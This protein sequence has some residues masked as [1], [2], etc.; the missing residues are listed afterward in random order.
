ML[1]W[2]L[3]AG[4]FFFCFGFSDNHSRYIGMSKGTTRERKL[5]ADATQQIDNWMRGGVLD[6]MRLLV[7]LEGLDQIVVDA[8]NVW[9][10]LFG[11]SIKDALLKFAKQ[12]AHRAE[13]GLPLLNEEELEAFLSVAKDSM[14]HRTKHL[15]EFLG[16]VKASHLLIA[17]DERK[18]MLPVLGKG[19]VRNTF[20]DLEVAKH[21][22]GNL[23]NWL[24]K[25]KDGMRGF[26]VVG[27]K[28]PG[29][30]EKAIR[31]FVADALHRSESGRQVLRLLVA[32]VKDRIAEVM[33]KIV[34]DLCEAREADI[35]VL[36][37]RETFM[38]GK[39]V[40]RE[41]GWRVGV[42]A[43]DL[44]VVTE[45][46]ARAESEVFLNMV[47]LS[48]TKLLVRK[49]RACNQ[50]ILTGKAKR[51]ACEL[52]EDDL[53]IGNHQL[54]LTWQQKLNLLFTHILGNVDYVV[55]AAET[56]LL[57][58]AD[59]KTI[60][61]ELFLL[62][63]RAYRG[64][65]KQEA[66]RNSGVVDV[67]FA[68]LV[69]FLRDPGMR[70]DKLDSL[71][72]EMGETARM[73]LVY[74]LELKRNLLHILY[75][76]VSRIMINFPLLQNRHIVME[77]V[78]KLF[79]PAFLASEDAQKIVV[80][81]ETMELPMRPL[82]TVT[83]A[84]VTVFLSVLIPPLNVAAK[85]PVIKRPKVA[86]D[87]APEERLVFRKAEMAGVLGGLSE[88][89]EVV[90]RKVRQRAD[91]LLPVIAA[92]QLTYGGLESVL[93]WLKEPVGPRPELQTSLSEPLVEGMKRLLIVGVAD[94]CL[95]ATSLL[96][97]Q[98]AFG[99][100][101]RLFVAELLAQDGA[102]RVF[103]DSVLVANERHVKDCW[104]CEAGMHGKTEVA[105][106]V[107]QHAH[108]LIAD[109]KPDVVVA[110]GQ[111]ASNLYMGLAENV[112]S[113][114]LPERAATALNVKAAQEELF[115]GS[116]NSSF[117][118]TAAALGMAGGD[119]ELRLYGQYCTLPTHFKIGRLEIEIQAAQRQNLT[120]TKGTAGLTTAK[121]NK[122]N[123]KQKSPV[124]L[125]EI[126]SGGYVRVT[127]TR[128]GVPWTAVEHSD[129]VR[130]M[131]KRKGADAP[132]ELAVLVCNRLRKCVYTY[133]QMRIVMMLTDQVR[134]VA[135]A[136]EKG[137]V[138]F[139]NTAYK[140]IFGLFGKA[141]VK[142]ATES[143]CRLVRLPGAAPVFVV[144]RDFFLQEV[145]PFVSGAKLESCMATFFVAPLAQD[146]VTRLDVV[147]RQQTLL[148][149]DT[150]LLVLSKGAVRS[151]S[152]AIWFAFSDEGD[153]KKMK[154]SLSTAEKDVELD[155]WE[156]VADDVVVDEDWGGTK[157]ALTGA[158]LDR[159]V[160]S[161]LQRLSAALQENA[162]A[163]GATLRKLM[164]ELVTGSSLLSG[165]HNEDNPLENWLRL[166]KSG[167]FGV[168]SGLAPRR[169]EQVVREG[170]STL[171]FVRDG[172]ARELFKRMEQW[173]GCRLAPLPSKCLP[174]HLP[175]ELFSSTP[176]FRA[177]LLSESPSLPWY[178]PPEDVGKVSCKVSLASVFGV[179]EASSI[180]Y[181]GGDTFSFLIKDH[182]KR[183][184][185]AVLKQQG[186]NGVQIS[187]LFGMPQD[188]DERR[189]EAGAAVKAR[190]AQ[191]K[192]PAENLQGKGHRVPVGRTVGLVAEHRLRN[193]DLPAQ[194]T[195][196]VEYAVL[197]AKAGAEVAV[198]AEMEREEKAA[199]K[200]AAEAAKKAAK[201]AG[202]SA[203]EAEMA[204]KSA[205]AK[206]SIDEGAAPAR[207]VEA[208]AEAE[209]EVR[210]E[211]RREAEAR[212]AGAAAEAKKRTTQFHVKL[213][214]NKASPKA[215]ADAF[216]EWLLTFPLAV[217]DFGDRWIASGIVAVLLSYDV[218]THVEEKTQVK[219]TVV[220]L[221]FA[222]RVVRVSGY[223][224]N[225]FHFK[226]P[227]SEEVPASPAQEAKA[228][229]Q[230][231]SLLKRFTDPDFL[232]ANPV[233][234][235]EKVAEV[236]GG[237]DAQ[238]RIKMT[239]E[240]VMQREQILR[241]EA[242]K[243]HQRYQSLDFVR[244]IDEICRQSG[245]GGD[246]IVVVG[247][248]GGGTGRRGRQLAKHEV[249]LKILAGFFT[250]FML[251][252]YCT[253]KNTTCCHRECNAPRSKGRSRGCKNK[254]CAERLGK[255]PWW[256]R[257]TGAAW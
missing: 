196:D 242:R 62:A 189:A 129:F 163:A 214:S 208:K 72:D 148:L 151:A 239:M 251:D 77:A 146:C 249:L 154:N 179:A 125:D 143:F 180:I 192:A 39:T 145:M 71:M 132:R 47:K 64:L 130:A 167:S 141:D 33:P 103:S 128:T 236:L 133:N 106:F 46:H 244:R 228:A 54:Q 188:R 216:L 20:T 136:G 96:A 126:D 183:T 10:K 100:T 99:D 26:A 127:A 37:S 25:A 4:V 65:L 173:S 169:T 49:P 218:T 219:T 217:L 93:L 257:D 82:G 15:V 121:K 190:V 17:L 240:D 104:I 186:N 222:F 60:P 36:N 256:D 223:K 254:E 250:V 135:A 215:Y 98:C 124:V 158:S 172:L 238:G 245:A 226:P 109:Y 252:E 27:K 13:L 1:A 177:Y 142:A 19:R 220:K 52:A 35:A 255:P 78:K 45:I 5:V 198:T 90:V 155:V 94:L 241:D 113:V 3:A 86:R 160:R 185:T 50:L 123:K 114:T 2:A 92:H 102:V 184:A 22:T 76:M 210:D 195:T 117:R 67:S 201:L 122:Q 66:E 153:R 225:H 229:H 181:A 211:T 32:D 89:E 34:I 221:E 107:M 166:L 134:A 199:K 112:F 178:R 29:A 144:L 191:G 59:G 8:S 83:N 6:R 253:S 170:K 111:E 44:D 197:K 12:I 16:L 194:E 232:K 61:S 147:A 63:L 56:K 159:K 246:P 140:E 18:E 101:A 206:V 247:T 193:V 248:G 87:T 139:D 213:Q 110:F 21:D 230:I 182:E 138:V 174:F 48:P 58:D 152:C 30:Q 137:V 209:K 42:F 164:S 162:F 69:R 118:Q 75:G 80:A 38:D 7:P 81:G 168:S 97:S 23:L 31:N 28:H 11:E 73:R 53:V 115:W 187:D 105:N 202:L 204:A 203:S 41:K 156:T 231:E 108:R 171:G 176:S 224:W 95:S 212:A 85:E 24:R 51:F 9:R 175:K 74:A 237:K 43:N 161:V 55:N 119:D 157:T 57:V 131:T 14:W 84:C 150:L 120:G 235:A 116:F 165:A 205:A 234:Q 200:E 88:K 70:I 91:V 233:E 68:R 79:A 149:L 227:E 207:I 40:E 243:K